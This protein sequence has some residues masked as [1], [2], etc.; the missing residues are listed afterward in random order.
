MGSDSYI[1]VV[2]LFCIYMCLIIIF[3]GFQ[4][5][6]LDFDEI[7]FIKKCKIFY[8]SSDITIDMCLEKT[9]GW[10]SY[11][12]L[13]FTLNVFQKNH[14]NYFNNELANYGLNL[15]QAV[16]LMVIDE[17]KHFNQK[18]L[19][20]ELH[21]TKGAITKAIRKLEDDGWI[22]REKSSDDKRHFVLKLTDKGKKGIPIFY[23]IKSEWESKMNVDDLSPEFVETFK[24]LASKAAELNE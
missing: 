23:H 11:N 16:C 8:I 4:Y 19:A 22:S 12:S 24:N 6:C 15:V 9:I 1:S 14:K 5:G 17:N 21:L 18:D 7:N 20:C 3:P 2:H 10:H 13:G